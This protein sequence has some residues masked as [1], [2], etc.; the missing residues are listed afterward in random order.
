MSSQS[1]GDPPSPPIQCSDHHL[2]VRE[3]AHFHLFLK[4]EL[5]CIKPGGPPSPPIQCSD[6]HL[7]VR[8]DAHLHLFLKQEL[9]CIK[10]E[11]QL[12]ELNP[13]KWMTE[14]GFPLTHPSSDDET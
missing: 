3:D 7:E 5:E 6:H 10:L 4:Q 14:K 11:L 12:T 8:E 2:E 13:Y 1:K 9:E